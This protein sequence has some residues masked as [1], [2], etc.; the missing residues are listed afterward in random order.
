MEAFGS[1]GYSTLIVLGAATR[2]RTAARKNVLTGS[3]KTIGLRAAVGC[4]DF[5]VSEKR[6]SYQKLGAGNIYLTIKEN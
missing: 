2:W 5:A 1:I 3:E 4:E 6:F